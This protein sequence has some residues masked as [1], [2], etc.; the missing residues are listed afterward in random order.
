[1]IVF[2]IA[3]GF[4]KLTKNIPPELSPKELDRL[5]AITIYLKTKDVSL[6]CKTFGISRATLY[7]WLKRY[8]PKDLRSLRDKSRRPKR[9]RKPR[10]SYELIIAVKGLRQLYPRWGKEKLVVLVGKEGFKTSASTVGR[11]IG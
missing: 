11:I 8:E 1:M 2:S 4:H 3:K 7:R 5:R 9:L 10:W 6:V